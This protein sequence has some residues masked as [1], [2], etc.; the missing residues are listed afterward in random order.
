MESFAYN[1][2]P[3]GTFTAFWNDEARKAT[4][5]LLGLSAR[6]REGSAKSLDYWRCSES[7]KYVIPI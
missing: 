7:V 6:G 1:H 5:G 2:E 4:K 3:L